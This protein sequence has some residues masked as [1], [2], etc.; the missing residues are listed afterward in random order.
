MFQVLVV[1]DESPILRNICKMVEMVNPLFHVKY[2]ARNGAEALKILEDASDIDFMMLDINTPIMNGL[3]L[4][5]ELR[6]RN[7]QVKIVI[8]S[9]FHEF[10]YIRTAMRNG[11][12]DYLTKPLKKEELLRVLSR[13]EELLLVE[14]YQRNKRRIKEMEKESLEGDYEIASVI[15]GGTINVE[16]A[17]NLYQIIEVEDILMKYL[18]KKYT[19]DEYWIINKSYNERIIMFKKNQ[20][21]NQM[22]WRNMDEIFREARVAV[23]MVLYQFP[24]THKTIHVTDNK[25]SAIVRDLMNVNKH[26]FYYGDGYEIAENN[27]AE[28]KKIKEQYKYAQYQSQIGEGLQKI[29][30]N[31]SGNRS[32]LLEVLKM[33][34]MYYLEK[35]TIQYSYTEMESRIRYCVLSAESLEQLCEEIQSLNIEYFLSQE[36]KEQSKSPMSLS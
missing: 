13:V 5:E 31:S 20:I 34:I 29:I 19:Q 11:A 23:T 21:K 9:G 25:L 32:V 26:V 2:R 36:E 7:I 30:I 10:E 15:F 1:E 22:I 27:F 35:F 16:E 33:Y 4:M 28:I 12:I 8:L 24:Q 18:E 14:N 3:E 6:L 17:T